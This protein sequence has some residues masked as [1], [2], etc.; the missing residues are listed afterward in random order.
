MKLDASLTYNSA[1]DI[2]EGF[3][4]DGFKDI[5]IRA[6]DAGLKIVASICDQGSS[7]VK[8]IQHLILDS[9]REAFS[10]IDGID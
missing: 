10:N 3:V 5:V 7:N 9:K 6:H 4:D 2:V 8:A 1:V